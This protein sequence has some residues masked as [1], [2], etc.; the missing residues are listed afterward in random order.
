MTAFAPFLIPALSFAAVA[1]V[2]FVIG[3]YLSA[4]AQMQRRLPASAEPNDVGAGGAFQNLHAVI[5]RRFDAKRFGVEGTPREKL[6][7]ELLKAGYF[8]AYAVN[9]Y[10]FARL[11]AV[12][13]F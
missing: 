7:R 3:H 10:I 11:T 9:Y 6:R 12:L 1:A 13:I 5:V 8:R 4:L 2:V